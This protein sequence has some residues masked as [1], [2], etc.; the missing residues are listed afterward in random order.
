MIGMKPVD[1]TT[2]QDTDAYELATDRD[3]VTCVRCL[4]GG[5][6]TQRDHRQNRMRNNTV[7]ENIQILCAT[8]HL[9]KGTNPHAA[10]YQGWGCPRWARPAEWPARRWVQTDVGT[11]RLTWILYVPDIE[12][13][14]HPDG[15][16]IITELEARNRMAGLVEGVRI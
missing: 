16:R 11:H 8:C 14:S 10:L 7:V 13:F 1:R 9:W 6:D 12:F 2:R 15:Y 4:R 3:N 5:E